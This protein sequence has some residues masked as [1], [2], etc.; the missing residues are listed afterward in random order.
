[1][2]LP[3]LLKILHIHMKNKN[4]PTKRDEMLLWEKVPPKQDRRF[5]KVEFL[6]GR[7]IYFHIFFSV[8]FRIETSHFFLA[9]NK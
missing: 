3:G 5:I 4:V 1:M 2:S 7:R 6:S 8:A 9:H